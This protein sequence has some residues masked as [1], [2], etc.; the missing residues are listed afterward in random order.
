M[1]DFLIGT[2]ILIDGFYNQEERIECLKV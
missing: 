1:P 2:I